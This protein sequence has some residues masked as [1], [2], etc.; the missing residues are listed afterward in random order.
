MGWS[1]FIRL[2]LLSFKYAKKKYYN[3]AISQKLFKLSKNALGNRKTPNLS[4]KKLIKSILMLKLFK[5][6]KKSK[7]IFTVY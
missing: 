1:L 7:E 3:R 4:K 6:F 2:A 5:I